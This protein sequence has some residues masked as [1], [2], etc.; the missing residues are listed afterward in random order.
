MTL[1][2]SLNLSVILFT[3]QKFCLPWKDVA[4]MGIHEQYVLLRRVCALG[5]IYM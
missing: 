1:G 2:K 5:A 4:E 3:S